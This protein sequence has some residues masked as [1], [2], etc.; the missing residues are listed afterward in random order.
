MADVAEGERAKQRVAQR[1]DG[2]V[3]VGMG[4]K[5]R[6]GGNLHAAQPHREVGRQ[7]V[8]VVSITYSD[9]HL[10]LNLLHKGNEFSGDGYYRPPGKPPPGPPKAPLLPE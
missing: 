10:S 7:G 8:H 9:I 2:H 6:G 1:V 3:A 5:A 4:H